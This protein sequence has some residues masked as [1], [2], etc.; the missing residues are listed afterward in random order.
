MSAATFGLL[1]AGGA[2]TRLGRDKALLPLPGSPLT[3]AQN[4]HRI[5]LETGL[6]V[7]LAA[8]DEARAA[9]LLP[10]CPAVVDGPGRGP[11]AAL[12]GAH[13]AFPEAALLTLA[14]DLPAVPAAL[15]RQLAATAGDWV[16][17]AWQEDG[18]Q[19]EPLCALYRPPALAA[20]ARR[21]AA[22]HF[23]LQGLRQEKGLLLTRLGRDQLAPF[24]APERLFAN[25][26]R[27]ADYAALTR[28]AEEAGQPPCR[29][30]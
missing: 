23:D 18:D 7:L 12:L 14:C 25:I 19:L 26:N 29:P 16:A 3:L 11:A 2:S 27:P 9:A 20:L 6:P 30:G 8:R 5:L 1:L 4:A 28:L 21:V 17:P 10:G 13:A 24:G 15:L 22:G